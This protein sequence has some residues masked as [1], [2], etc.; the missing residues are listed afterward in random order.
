MPD[1]RYQSTNLNIPNLHPSHGGPSSIN[2]FPREDEEH[3]SHS[4]KEQIESFVGSYSR[5]SMMHM[6][7]NVLI[8]N[9]GEMMNEEEGEI[10]SY[11]SRYNS[12]QESMAGSRRNSEGTLHERMSLLYPSL[13]KRKSCASAIT[14]ADSYL[15]SS[16]INTITSNNSSG[17]SSKSSFLQSIFNSINILIGIGILALPLGFKNAGWVLSIFIFLFCFG[18]TNY[19]AKLLVK[20]LDADPNSKTYGDVGAYVYGIKGRVFISVLFITELITCSVALVVLLSDGIE[21]LFPGYHPILI[22]FVSYLI[23]TPTLFIP[24]RHLS[25]TSLLGI[26]SSFSLLAIILYDGLSKPTTP[27]SLHEMADTTLFPKDWMAVP[28]SFGLIMAGFAGHAVFPTIYRDMKHPSDYI[29]LTVAVS[30]YIMFGSKTMQEITQNLVSIPE[31]NQLLNRFAV[32]LIALNPIAKYGLT[33]NPVILSWQIGLSQN[34]HFKAWI[35]IHDCCWKKTLFIKV[36]G[37]ILTSTFIVLLA[38]LIPDFDQIMSLLGSLFSFIISGIFPLL[39]YLK[40][41]QHSLT[42]WQLLFNYTLILVATMMAI[43]GTIRAFI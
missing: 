43:T 30:G 7:E 20:C 18:L 4:F 33:L 42:R 35:D 34:S 8:S 1:K 13:Q 22:R 39:C 2:E 5:T 16:H 9:T 24:V 40:L 10:P 23:L 36:M 27:G 11:L 14:V 17:S 6:A 25:Y 28:M 26:L 37:T 15:S 32:Y 21:S 19:T 12:H 38:I 31:Y 41:F 3:L 29:Y